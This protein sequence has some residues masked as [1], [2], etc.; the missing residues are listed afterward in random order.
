MSFL[1]SDQP[2]LPSDSGAAARWTTVITTRNSTCQVIYF[3]RWVRSHRDWVIGAAGKKC[4]LTDRLRNTRLRP[5]APSRRFCRE[6]AHV[7]AQ[8][9]T[10]LSLARRL[11]SA[12]NNIWRISARIP[13]IW[14]G[15][16]KPVSAMH[17]VLLLAFHSWGAHQARGTR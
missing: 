12:A 14:A 1:V 11:P 6:L 16:E 7:N 15:E 5:F 4:N 8:G 10:A 2:T 17:T 3:D 9:A 13:T